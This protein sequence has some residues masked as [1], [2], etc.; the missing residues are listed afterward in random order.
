M[1]NFKVHDVITIDGSY[2]DITK[3]KSYGVY[4]LQG[5]DYVTV[6]DDVFEEQDVHVK[7]CILVSTTSTWYIPP[8]TCGAIQN[9]PRGGTFKA[10]Y[11]LDPYTKTATS[12]DEP[13][14]DEAKAKSRVTSMG[15]FEAGTVVVYRDGTPTLT[16]LTV[17]RCTATCVWF[18]ETYSAAFNPDEFKVENSYDY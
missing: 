6:I 14:Y 15:D 18:E 4:M 9:V 1:S 16:C 17:K 7:D 8:Q 3:G 13:S 2:A 12:D 10:L 5:T 11:S